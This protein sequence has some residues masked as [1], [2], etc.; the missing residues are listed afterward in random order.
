MCLK[1][2]AKIFVC[3]MVVFSLILLGCRE[4]PEPIPVQPPTCPLGQV[5]I[6]DVC[7]IDANH[8]NVC[9][10]Q[11]Q[12][13]TPEPNSTLP[14]PPVINS[15]PPQPPIIIPPQ[16][17]ETIPVPPPPL[18]P[19]STSPVGITNL[20]P[21]PFTRLGFSTLPAKGVSFKD[22]VFGTT[23]MRLT[24]ATNRGSYAV[25]LYSQL[26]AFSSDNQYLFLAEG[27]E[28]GVQKMS[29]LS[30]VTGIDMGSWNAPRWY[31]KEAHSII[32]YDTNEDEIVRVQVTNIDTKQTKTVFTFPSEFLRVL[33]NPS[34]DELSED[35]RWTGGMVSRANGNDLLFALD[36]QNQKLGAQLSLNTLYG[37]TCQKDPQWG[38]VPP[39]W[40]GVSPLGKYLIVQWKRDGSTRCS[41]MEAFDIQTGE[42]KGR[43]FENHHHGDLAVTPEGKEV[44]VTVWLE[45][46]NSDGYPALVYYDIP[47]SA[48]PH[49]I[50]TLPWHGLE[51][52]SCR[53]PS[54]VCLLT[55]YEA[56]TSW[57][58]QDVLESEVYLAFFDGS[59]RRL[60]KHRSS[61][62]GYW[63]QPRASLSSDGEFAIFDSDFHKE[64]GGQ[65]S[66][67]KL[68]TDEGGGEIFAIPLTSEDLKSPQNANGG[69]LPGMGTPPVVDPTPPQPPVVPS[70][71]PNE[72]I[73]VPQ[74]PVPPDNIGP[75]GLPMQTYTLKSTESFNLNLAEGEWYQPPVSN[76]KDFVRLLVQHNV[77]ST[78]CFAED[79]TNV[80]LF[81]SDNGLTYQKVPAQEILD[82]DS[83]GCAK[84]NIMY[85]ISMQGTKRFVTC[86]S[87]SDGSQNY[88]SGSFEASTNPSAVGWG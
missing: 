1:M 62:C 60:T 40:V 83:G 24:D 20:N 54:G 80:R 46:P 78:E 9:D 73:P 23:L 47:T 58:Y 67:T 63:V 25:H 8:N 43:V 7:C 79:F 4:I 57:Q 5:M 39:D 17:N 41:G 37:G 16:P 44:F 21:I 69:K 29:D 45:D 11:E 15:T 35:G 6:N 22:P 34:F 70:P 75:N 77:G 26:Q 42:F 66:C 55:S 86:V 49:V 65:S 32:H 88:C 33:V 85:A 50:R 14:I 87:Q 68:R 59:V 52:I 12:V 48:N 28:Y 30:K 2:K 19:P 18:P 84:G 38:I 51:H 31:S 3:V 72:T 56:E 61:N 81:S 27:G 53:G 10:D 36:V 76:G 64:L 74:P 13:P 71:Q 82:K